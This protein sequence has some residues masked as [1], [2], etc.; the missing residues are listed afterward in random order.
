MNPSAKHHSYEL[1]VEEN[2]YM[3]AFQTKCS[4]C[5]RV[6]RECW[7]IL[8]RIGD[9]ASSYAAIKC[10]NCVFS[11]TKRVLPEILR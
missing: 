1:N 3:A 11:K 7:A 6:S 9:Q 2:K 5:V 10:V 8:V 4:L